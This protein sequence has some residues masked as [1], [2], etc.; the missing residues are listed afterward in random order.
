MQRKHIGLLRSPGDRCFE[1][2]HD[3]WSNSV[4]LVGASALAAAAPANSVNRP[5]AGHAERLQ[6]C[7]PDASTGC[8][9]STTVI[10]ALPRFSSLGPAF[11]TQHTAWAACP[12]AP[13]QSPCWSVSMAIS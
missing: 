1:N 11:G 13:M 8:W 2:L 12:L 6:P 4:T 10:A 9:A 3:P 7:V 5:L